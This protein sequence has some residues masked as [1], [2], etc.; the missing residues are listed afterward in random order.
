M[1]K[2]KN[3]IVFISH[4]SSMSGAPI[5]LLPLIN[6]IQTRHL[7]DLTIVLKRGGPLDEN[8]KKLGEVIILKPANYQ[9]GKSLWGKIKDYLGYKQRLDKVLNILSKSDLIVS[10]TIANGQLLKILSSQQKPIITYVHELKSAMEICDANKDTTLS[11]QLSNAFFSPT[12]AVT[13]NLVSNYNVDRNKIFGLNYYFKKVEEDILQSR[14][15][16][17]E[18]FLKT[19]GLPP[20]K[21]YVAGMGSANLRK[22]IDLFLD[23]CAFVTRIDND[24]H[25]V[26]IGDFIDEGTKHTIQQKMAQQNLSSYFTMT[27]FIPNNSTNLLPFDVF[28]LTSREDP[29]PL[30]VLEAAFLEIP[31]IAFKGNGGMDEFIGK[32][33]GFLISDQS[34][35]QFA[36]KIIA[37]KNDHPT[38]KKAGIAAREKALKLHADESL[39][40]DQFIRGISA[41]D[42]N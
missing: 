35:Q 32:E 37:L 22:G 17:K 21:F 12:P 4:E 11:L 24:V 9:V 31:A 28:A 38:L 30:V 8:F 5:L 2:E 40:I 18:S 27:G 29:Y 19:Y 6:L 33:A 15:D 23:I 13:Q 41:V 1:L 7:F 25:F 36:E 14:T 20:N 3:K 10:N 42:Q 26:W 39:I 34:V 16:K